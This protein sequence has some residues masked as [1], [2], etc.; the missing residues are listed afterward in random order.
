MTALEW[1]I[2]KSLIGY[3]RGM[4]DGRILVGDGATASDDGVFVF[5]GDDELR[6]RGSVTLLGHDGMM[7]VVVQDPWIERDGGRWM[8]SI[9]DPDD[10]ARLAFVTI[11]ALGVDEDG[12]RHGTGVALTSDGADLFFGPYVEGTAFDDLVI[13]G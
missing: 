4:D 8:L 5:P 11:E 7:R 9:A 3:V 12:V 1:G 10:P 2:K 13:T 6:F